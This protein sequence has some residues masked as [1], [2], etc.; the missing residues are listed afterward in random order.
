MHWDW[1]SSS[2]AAQS[3]PIDCATYRVRISASAESVYDAAITA[4]CISWNRFTIA[5]SMADGLKY[6]ARSAVSQRPTGSTRTCL[7]RPSDAETAV[8]STTRMRSTLWR[9]SRLARRREQRVTRYGCITLCGSHTLALTRR[10]PGKVV[11]RGR[12]GSYLPP[13]PAQIPA[14][15]IT[16][17]GSCLR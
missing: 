6:C 3:F 11:S 15:R 2:F 1:S 8:L 10:F 7:T 16:A 12:S 4:S 17:Q 13:P 9:G 5:R 14:G